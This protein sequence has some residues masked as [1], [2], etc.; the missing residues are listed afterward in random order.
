MAL[1][2]TRRMWRRFSQLAC[3]PPKA[4][5]YQQSV[6]HRHRGSSELCHKA[7][8]IHTV[9]G[10]V[11]R[12]STMINGRSRRGGGLFKAQRQ[13]PP[14]Q[15]NTINK[16]NIPW[17]LV[18]PCLVAPSSSTLFPPEESPPGNISK[19][20]TKQKRK[21]RLHGLASSKLIRSCP[22]LDAHQT[23]Q[24]TTHSILQNSLLRPVSASLPP[25]PHL[26]VSRLTCTQP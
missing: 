26:Q 10:S 13:P 20:T 9:Q 22:N 1:G 16:E 23:T 19:S 5:E 11:T 8:L 25:P 21:K 3:Q 15:R 18:T 24:H 2:A 14:P 6:S 12:S 4:S 7:R 17:A